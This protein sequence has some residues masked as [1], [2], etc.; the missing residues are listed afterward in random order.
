MW[1]A[2]LAVGYAV[3][4]PTYF[5]DTSTTV[6]GTPCTAAA[7]QHASAGALTL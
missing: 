7:T 4:N 6:H 3:F 1:S 2:I 5:T